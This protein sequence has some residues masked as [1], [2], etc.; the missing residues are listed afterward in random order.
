MVQPTPYKGVRCRMV[1]V[2][3]QVTLHVTIHHS[4]YAAPIAVTSIVHRTAA[5][6]R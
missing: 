1:P 5:L 6:A 2:S 4:G 3:D